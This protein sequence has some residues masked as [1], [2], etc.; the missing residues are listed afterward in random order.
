MTHNE[1]SAMNE[2]PASSCSSVIITR[3]SGPTMSHS[4]TAKIENDSPSSFPSS[5]PL[6]HSIKHLHKKHDS[7]DSRFREKLLPSDE[8]Q[9]HISTMTAA[10]S[11]NSPHDSL[12]IVHQNQ[13]ASSQT[14]C[15]NR[16]MSCKIRH[17]SQNP[18][19]GPVHHKT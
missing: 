9:N 18:D 15:K 7:S 10:A 3:Q 1:S 8:Q 2:L 11:R 14:H 5:F 12:I 4:S 6:Q 13:P 16:S 17:W 19:F